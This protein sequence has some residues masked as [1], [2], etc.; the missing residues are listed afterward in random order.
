MPID[1]TEVETTAGVNPTDVTS[2]F[3]E[4][5]EL[6]AGLD[7]TGQQLASI[8]VSGNTRELTITDSTVISS[9]A[10]PFTRSHSVLRYSVT[11]FVD[12]SST[13]PQKSAAAHALG[14]AD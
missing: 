13:T 5:T 11:G 12:S 6:P 7:S 9:I 4:Y 1:A 3:D 8:R 10:D 2:I 14:Y